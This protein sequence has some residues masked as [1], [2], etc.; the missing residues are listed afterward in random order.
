MD[1][2]VARSREDEYFAKQEFARL[3]KLA[4]ENAAR[5][6]QQELDELKHVHWMRCRRMGWSWLRLSTWG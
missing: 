4:E 5:L 2:K 1:N 3:K 6:K